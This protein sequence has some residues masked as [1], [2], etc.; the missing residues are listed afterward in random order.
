MIDLCSRVSRSLWNR[1]MPES[2]SEVVEDETHEAPP[3][4]CQ[5]DLI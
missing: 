1:R 5:F 2:V 4:L 3:I